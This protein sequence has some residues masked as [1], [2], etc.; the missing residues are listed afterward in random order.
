[1]IHSVVVGDVVLFDPGENIPCDGIFVSHHNVWCDE[2][3][4]TGK[5]DAIKKLSYH[6]CIALRI[7]NG[8]GFVTRRG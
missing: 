1:M 4:A 3:G 8:R 6:E 2:S 5:S 7:G